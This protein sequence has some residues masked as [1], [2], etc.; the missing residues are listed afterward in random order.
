MNKY[1]NIKVVVDNIKF[2]SKME[3]DYYVYLKEQKRKDLI[4]DF[5]LQPIFVLQPSF[6][7]NGKTYR[8]IEY[9]ADFKIIHNDSSI[10]IVDIKGMETTEFK[11]KQKIF[12]YKYPDLHLQCLTYVKKYGGW[13][14]LEKLKKIRREN[15]RKK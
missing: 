11:L 14:Q 10:S 2:D 5:E 1:G 7:K 15:R 12:E 3:S 6:K 8:K 4:K 9:R 13:I